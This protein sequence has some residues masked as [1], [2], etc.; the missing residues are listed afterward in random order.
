MAFA[1]TISTPGTSPFAVPGD[2]AGHP[3]SF[4]VVAQDFGEADAVVVEQCDGADPNS[5]SWSVTAHCDSGSATAV[6]LADVNGTA[7]FPADDP[8]VGFHPFKG[9]SPSG[10]FN[11]LSPNQASPN[12]GLTDYRNCMIRVSTSLTGATPDQALLA[13]ELP[14]PGG[15]GTTTSVKPTTTTVQPTTTTTLAPTTTTVQ[16]TTTTLAP[17]TTTVQPTTTTLAP[18]TT[19]LPPTTTTVKP[20]TTTTHTTTTTLPPPTTTVKPTTTTGPPPTTAPPPVT[21]SVPAPSTTTTT[22]APA[23]TT[24]QPATGTTVRSTG[25]TATAAPRTPATVDPADAPTIARVSPRTETLPRTGAPIGTLVLA[26]LT[27]VGAGV[28]LVVRTRR[29]LLS[30]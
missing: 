7:T 10:Q 13:I 19:T 26:A 24:S 3:L 5:P 11:C 25:T 9:A 28:G 1:G 12:N 20:T 27:L 30:Y 4:T 15:P 16:P 2:A 17:T 18:T 14:E 22:A 6:V 29:R 8:V 21:T 23:T